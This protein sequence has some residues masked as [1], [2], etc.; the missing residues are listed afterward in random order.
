MSKDGTASIISLLAATAASFCCIIPLIALAAG[1]SGAASSLSWLVPFRPYLIALSVV[2]LGFAWYQSLRT[3]EAVP[4]TTDGNC[5]VEKKHFLASK[6]FL[7][8]VTITTALIVAFPNYSKI[9]YQKSSA[10]KAIIAERSN[11]QT[12]KFEIKGMTC[13]GCEAHVNNELSKVNGVVKPAT[14]F[15]KRNTVVHF[16][17]TKTTVQQLQAAIAKTGYRVIA[18]KFESNG[19]TR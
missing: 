3:K 14:S 6:N 1:A 19:N 16:D 4:C 9:F 13:A 8:L 18:T 11:I 5:S 17:V 10:A 12:V 7:L 2:A 15:A